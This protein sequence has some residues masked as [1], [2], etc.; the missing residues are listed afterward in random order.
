MLV[1]LIR[2]MSFSQ[3]IQVGK[4]KAFGA[5]LIATDEA[6]RVATFVLT[7]SKSLKDAKSHL[8]ELHNRGCKIEIIH[9]GQ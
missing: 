4:V 3:M 6:G 8:E 5:L 2:A 9:T 7:P 1:K